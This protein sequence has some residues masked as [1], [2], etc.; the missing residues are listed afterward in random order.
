MCGNFNDDR[1]DDFMT[2]QMLPETFAN[3]FGDS[4]K[5]ES[6]CP[7][8]V[9]PKNPCATN[10]HRAPWA[11][12]MCSVIRR[13]VFKPCHEVVSGYAVYRTARIMAAK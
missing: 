12:K 7:D 4:W 11:H 9:V 2:P 8:A 3:D 13:D 6:S 5:V 10:K 1:N